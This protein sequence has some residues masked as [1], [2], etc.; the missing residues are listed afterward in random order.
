MYYNMHTDW[1]L[2]HFRQGYVN[3]DLMMSSNTPNANM[4]AQQLFVWTGSQEKKT[5]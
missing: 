2:S 1:L 5:N 4:A 3:K